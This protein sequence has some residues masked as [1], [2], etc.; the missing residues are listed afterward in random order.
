MQY[1]KPFFDNA[2]HCEPLQRDDNVQ[3]ENLPYSNNSL[4]NNHATQ[5]ARSTQKRSG[6]DSHVAH[7]NHFAQRENILPKNFS[8]HDD[9]L[10]SNNTS[11]SENPPLQNSLQDSHPFQDNPLQRGNSLQR[12][13]KNP[14]PDLPAATL[15]FYRDVLQILN[16]EGL[17]Y[18][19]GGAYALNHYAG[20]N[21]LTKDFDIFIAREDYQKISL[22]LTRAGYPVEMTYPHWLAKAHHNGDFIDL[23]FSS[24]NGVAEVDDAWF[25]HSEETKIFCI[26]T[27]VCPA[28]EIIWSK[29]FIME[30]ERFDGAD[31]A[32][33][34]LACGDRIDWSRL[35]Q[36]FAP[37]WR[38]LLSHL[39]LFGMIYPAHRDVVPRWVMQQLL[40]RLD[41]ESHAPAPM[42]EICGGTLLSR[43]QYLRDIQ[44]LGFKDARI[45]P[46]GN[47]S[48][49][50]TSLW[51]DAIPPR[52]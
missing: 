14:Q 29:A 6:H 19:V 48:E 24:G 5:N 52:I 33:L 9:I 20:V 11:P 16:R 7:D 23:V 35:M 30:R 36:R 41:K 8:Q 47:M 17:R 26:E 18:L 51:T 3:Y 31:I 4:Q 40:K 34:L 28:E 43:E 37:H 32:H 12:G 45:W 2:T 27:R 25:D 38:L 1:V 39:I 46:H 13:N 49:Q 50:E 44:N 42:E 10:H 22:T 15:G 21:R